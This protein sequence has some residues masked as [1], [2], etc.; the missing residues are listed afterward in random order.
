MT[1]S[2]LVALD[3]AHASEQKSI[4]LQAARIASLDNSKISLITVVPDYDMSIV[5][6]YFH[7][8]AIREILEDAN[9]KLHDLANDVLGYDNQVRCLVSKGNAYEEIL[10]AAE[11]LDASMIAMGAHKPSFKDYLLG[12]NAA[13]VMRHA[14]CSVLVVREPD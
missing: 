10:L 11:K 13:R 14:T 5:G 8:D 4:L 12:P 7:E 3:V 9:T 6:S 1:G 2:I